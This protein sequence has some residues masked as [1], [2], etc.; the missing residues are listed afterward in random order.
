MPLILKEVGRAGGGLADGL[1]ERV[2]RLA[3]DAVAVLVHVVAVP[4]LDVGADLQG[5]GAGGGL[6]R[7][8]DQ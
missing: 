7:E 4:V 1:D 5:I 2:G 6:G 8:R 3:I